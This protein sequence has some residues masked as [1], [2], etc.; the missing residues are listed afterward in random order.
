MTPGRASSACPACVGVGGPPGGVGQVGIGWR[1]E[2]GG[3]Q[4]AR[5]GEVLGPRR[6]VVRARLKPTS[7]ESSGLC[8]GA[9]R[10]VKVWPGA[11]LQL[12]TGGR[13]GQRGWP[14]GLRAPAR[15]GYVAPGHLGLPRPTDCP[16]GLGPAPHAARFRGRMG[17]CCLAALPYRR[18]LNGIRR[19]R[20]SVVSNGAMEP[21]RSRW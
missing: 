12:P 3:A 10:E 7:R 8:G 14:S 13:H 4:P 1:V 18:R 15:W 11:S 21:R 5:G 9:A 6:P 19:P 16:A 20:R 2:F 17:G